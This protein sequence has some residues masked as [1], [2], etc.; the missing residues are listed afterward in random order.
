[1]WGFN[2]ENVVA[3]SK[4][5]AEENVEV[6]WDLSIVADVADVADMTG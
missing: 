2:L 5:S 1:L 4:S 3:V 6:V